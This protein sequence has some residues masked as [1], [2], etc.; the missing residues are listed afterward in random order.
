ME[1]SWSARS[2]L[3]GTHSAACVRIEATEF[4]FPKRLRLSD[5]KD[6]V[7]I[8]I[9]EHETCPAEVGSLLGDDGG[10]KTRDGDRRDQHS[11]KSVSG[12]FSPEA[13]SRPTSHVMHAQL[14]RQA[15][16]AD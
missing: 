6:A 12:G 14:S 10:G 3:F 2:E 4:L 7:S 16:H 15:S 8:R 9:G 13:A 1:R 11:L 5:P